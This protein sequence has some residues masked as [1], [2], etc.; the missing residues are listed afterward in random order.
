MS[1]TG[2]PEKRENA[3]LASRADRGCDS[4]EARSWWIQSMNRNPLPGKLCAGSNVARWCTARLSPWGLRRGPPSLR[5]WWRSSIP[6]I[7]AAG[8][9]VSRTTW[10]RASSEGCRRWHRSSSAAVR[11]AKRCAECHRPASGS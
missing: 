5:C 2:S 6:T 3:S 4:D 9:S 8:V 10:K 7:S 11:H 1:P